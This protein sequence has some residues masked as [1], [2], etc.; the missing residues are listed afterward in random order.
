MLGKLVIMNQ[1]RSAPL[2]IGELTFLLLITGCRP[3]PPLINVHRSGQVKV[4]EV[5][6]Q[7][8]YKS[9]TRYPGVIEPSKSVDLSFEVPGKLASVSVK[10]GES[11]KAGQVLARLDCGE[12][13]RRHDG[14]LAARELA[15]TSY[16]RINSVFSKGSVAEIKMLE[17]KSAFEQA[18]ALFQANGTLLS[19]YVL[20]APFSGRLS[21][22][23]ADPGTVTGPGSA[24]LQLVDIKTVK[25]VCWL[26]AAEIRSVKLGDSVSIDAFDQTRRWGLVD[27]IGLVADPASP[28]Y[29]VKISVAN[30]DGDLLPGMS[31]RVSFPTEGAGESR[32]ARNIVIPSAAVRADA[33]GQMY[34]LIADE[35]SGKAVR[36]DVVIDGGEGFGKIIRS[37]LVEGD[38]IIVSGDTALQASDSV[39][40]TR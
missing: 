16:D 12:V 2:G 19:K 39:T 21:K 28:V 27:E 1:M 6:V 23:M 24:I 34:V 8:D 14:L 13:R 7:N 15:R 36:R 3:A 31:C 18:D 9:G 22:R 11:V 32:R 4:Y 30:N 5:A 35:Q 10:E 17:S 26:G 33:D 29:P 40:I 25:V 37:G 38:K 20:T